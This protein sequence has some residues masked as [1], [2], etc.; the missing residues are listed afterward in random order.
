MEQF[1]PGADYGSGYR[2]F[3]WVCT[4]VNPRSFEQCDQPTSVRVWQTF[5][6]KVQTSGMGRDTFVYT[7]GCML[8]CKA[9]GTTV[10][11]Y[12]DK[13]VTPE[14]EHMTYYRNVTE[15][16]VERILEAL[17]NGKVVA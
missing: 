17:R 5:L 3:I 1:R 6:Q 10:A 9:A 14:G 12:S 8:G 7:S 13:P 4:Q 2:N 11:V 16:D 15:G